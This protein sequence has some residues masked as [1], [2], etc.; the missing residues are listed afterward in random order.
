MCF[1]A[2]FL[3]SVFTLVFFGQTGVTPLPSLGEPALSPDRSEIAFVSGG[4]I[5]TVPAKGGEAHLLVSH[6]ATESR[7]LYSPDGTKLAFTSTRTGNGDIY[8]LTFTTGEVKRLTY[9]DS[10]DL[11]DGW[12]RDGKWLYFSS[13][14]NDI[15][16]AQDVFRVSVKGGT[17]LEVLHD[18]F[19]NEF[20]G[21]PSP[22]G[23]QIAFV[24]KGI[25]GNQWWRH[26]HSHLDESEIWLKAIA[27][28]D[29]YQC[30]VAEDAKQGWP[31][32][33]GDGKDL[34]YTSDRTGVENIF[35][36]PINGGPAKQIS[37]L[38]DG[39]LLWP[40]ISYDGREIVFE[41]GFKI[42]KLDTK[43]GSA[44]EVTIMLRGAAPTPA[45]THQTLTQF[46]DL[47]LSHDGKKVAV[48][49]HGEVFAASATD[50]GDA[51]RITRTS[52]P[53]TDLEWAPDSNRLV[54]VSSRNGH[55]QIFE[56]DLS[57]NAER[58]LTA[59]DCDDE[60]P[61]FSPDGKQ[62]AFV[63]DWHELHT[64][65]LPAMKDTLLSTG[66]LRNP[67]LAWSPDSK[68]LAFT[69]NG[70][71]SFR[72]VSVVESGG[73]PARPVSFLANGQTASRIAW[74]P[75][76]KYLLFNTAQRSELSQM[77]RV[78][79]QSHLPKF[80]ED[81]FRELFR[82][83]E[84]APEQRPTTRQSEKDPPKP[85]DTE[86]LT[87]SGAPPSPAG[88]DKTPKKSEP[89]VITF[90]GIRE[91]LNFLPLGLDVSEPV[92]SPDGKT[93][94][95]AATIGT[96]RNLYS[97]SLDELAAEP[98]VARQLT[99]TPSPKSDYQFSAD[100]KTIY[101]LDS[102]HVNSMPLD[103]RVP[104]PITVTA[105][106]DIDFDADKVATFEQGWAILNK[107]FYDSK[108]HGQNWTRL[109]DL[110]APYI[111]GSHTPDE[112]RRVMNLMIG[113]LNA[114]HSGINPAPAPSVQPSAFSP[115]PTPV[116]RLGL[117][118]ER[119]P[120]EAGKGLIIREIIPLSPAALEGT[121]KV[122]EI[123]LAVDEES[124]TPQTNLD[125]L[126]Q[127]KVNRRV[128]LRIGSAGNPAQ[129]REA[130]VRPDSAS[131][132]K[133]LLYR[134]WVEANRAYVERISHG[135][136]GYVHIADMSQ[137]SLNQLYI[138]L[139][140]QNQTKEGVVVDIRD[141]NGG[142][143]NEY[144]I[145]VFTRKNYLTMTPRSGSPA[146]A[147][148]TLGQRA[149]GLPTI[150]VTNQ[151]SLSDAED[152]TEG[153]RALKLGKVVGEPTAGWIIYTGAAQLLDGSVIR[154][155]FIRVQAADGTDMEMH[156]RP[157]DIPVERMA[158]D[159]L[160]GKDIQLD[161]AVAELLREVSHS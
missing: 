75:D 5:W 118:F 155:P 96:Q 13:N 125:N 130:V 11:L 27:D 9:S 42:W 158:G 83:K 85:T 161:R 15:N 122:G 156:P 93:L 117:H 39:R 129:T 146:P 65:T 71:K 63:R 37:H 131:T 105:A 3:L 80:R 69:S 103:T 19:Y 81:Q 59:S 52:A 128:V 35:R 153:Y 68:F 2:V 40:S 14:V 132:E 62:L 119:E 45:V 87:K 73:S 139:D 106:L 102:G 137:Q 74:S 41:R 95:F 8:V 97:Y 64:L 26:G 51:L 25:S 104:K 109:H 89:T 30:L 36:Q 79:L 76:G 100:S 66:D 138:D 49:A 43:S 55:H 23:M 53:E 32:W 143:V 44:S 141:N 145:D 92:I 94:L 17:P 21:A 140:V 120:Y 150:L 151:G 16:Q 149:L 78:D 29:P 114:S 147:R 72:N 10:N 111:A 1:R 84:P 7:P 121:I 152:F 144:A 22:D 67:V 123:L 50:G 142:F 58:Q 31:M 86:T 127:S 154:T 48:I 116:G 38:Q 101:F 107:R 135:K 28:K 82:N 54:Y 34:Y 108:F 57:K 115:T 33:S 60:V 99:T 70:A 4:D 61:H 126:L 157:V 47:A 24:A 124:I 46:T 98:P 20:R 88:L 160:Q 136:L 134:S 91:R 77:A 133:G 18:R 12:S 112:M 90:E 56:Y 148:P 6:P 159:W 113:E 110:Y